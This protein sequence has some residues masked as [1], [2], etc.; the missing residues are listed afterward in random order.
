MA[1]KDASGAS[2][3]HIKKQNLER[4][5][6]NGR[7]LIA[8]GLMLGGCIVASARAQNAPGGARHTTAG[9]QP[10]AETAQSPPKILAVVNGQ[11]ITRETL[12]NEALRRYGQDVL[13]TLI[14]RQ[15]IDQACEARQVRITEQD[16]E[17]EIR[18]VAERFGMS[19]DRWL[20]VLQTER[21]VEPQQYREDIIRPTLALRRMASKQIRVT[22]EE[23]RLAFESEYG[24]QVR[25]RLIAVS[26]REKAEWL[27]EAAVADPES[28]PRLAKEHSEDRAT[29]SAYGVIPPIRKHMGA[30]EVEEVAFQLKP[31]EISPVIQ[32]GNQ[33]LILKCEKHIER[34]FV[35]SDQMPAIE[36]EIRQRVLEHKKREEATRVFQDIREQAQITQVLGDAD[37]QARYPGLAA[38]VNGRQITLRQLAEECLARHGEDVLMGEINRQLLR[39]E[40]RRRDL[41]VNEQDIDREV[42]RAAQAF[43]YVDADGHADVEAWLE[44]V[45]EGDQTTIELYVRDA[46]WPTVALKKLVGEEV[47]VSDEALQKGFE[48]NFGERVEL[49]AIVLGSHRQAQSVWEMA[50][51][52]PTDQFFG[53]LAHQYSMEPTSRANFGRVPPLRRH[54]GQPLVEK[55]AFRL[56]P[57]ELS[58][59]IAVGEQYVILRC[60]GRTDPVVTD[61]EVVREELYKDL[62]EKKLRLAMAQEFDRL[63]DSAQIDNFLAGTSQ[64]GR[65]TTAGA[66]QPSGA[67]PAATTASRSQR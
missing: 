67:R 32:V 28:F 56:K 46:V 47:E 55:E 36:E 12:A 16:V 9:P 37:Q 65:R 33:Y 11:E 10:V 31:N 58:G 57:G 13:D 7:F 44:A 2:R 34:T 51:N 1:G 49:L 60:L 22:E 26:S 41:V 38:V 4:C 45:A 18:R 3:R 48:S 39:Q 62:H 54:S 61:F 66:R 21:D 50:R 53:E 52:N 25:A 17:E 27:R 29:A 5:P 15:I 20:S 59:I 30:S 42:T 35:S 24:P 43:G 8:V 63:R 23:F 6:L 14:H 64:S 40:L 19:L